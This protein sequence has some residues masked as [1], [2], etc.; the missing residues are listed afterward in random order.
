MGYRWHDTKKI[1]PKYSF[2]H[3]LSYTDFKYGKAEASAKEMTESG[4]ILINVPVTNVGDRK[5]KET[6]QL[7]IGDD[8]ATVM[9]PVKELKGFEKISLAPGETRNVTFTIK[10]DDLKFYDEASK[11]WK[12]EPGKFTAY[13][14]SSS[15]DIRCKIP[16]TL[17]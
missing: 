1:A 13:I 7:Y 14:G 9:R 5:G 2:G 11:G 17:K 12:A 4:T 6:V 16:F 3:G 10:A 15:T 8:K